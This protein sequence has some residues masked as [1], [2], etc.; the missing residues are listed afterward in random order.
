MH[1]PNANVDDRKPVLALMK[2][3]V[4][5][6]F[7]DKGYI[8]KPLAT[9]LSELGVKLLTT[10]KKNMKSKTLPAEI[11]DVVYSKKRSLIESVINI[12][13]NK[14]QLCHTRHRSVTN[15]MVHTVATMLGYQLLCKKPKLNF[16]DINLLNFG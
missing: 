2:G 13:K 11:I 12:L 6:L 3:F 16:A 8:S 10:S 7:G 1:V 14:L 9:A 15:F 5:K 4:G